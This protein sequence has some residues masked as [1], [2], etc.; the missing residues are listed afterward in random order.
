MAVRSG[1][2]PP[3]A[4]AARGRPAAATRAR[5][6]RSRTPP[7]SAGPRAQPAWRSGGAARS[8][9]RHAEQQAAPIVSGHGE[10]QG[11][12]STPACSMRGTPSGRRPISPPT[13]AEA[14]SDAERPAGERRAPRSRS[15][16]AGRSASANRADGGAHGQLA[17]RRAAARARSMLETLRHAIRRTRPTAPNRI[18]ETFRLALDQ[19]VLDRAHPK[20]PLGPLQRNTPA[21]SRGHDAR[22]SARAWPRPSRRA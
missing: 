13:A 9:R 7:G 22:A 2:P 3:T 16:A 11:R 21:A 17:R 5:R 15:A 18:A 4:G 8:D 1:G 14:S 10:S 20:V 6:P 19:H 12:E